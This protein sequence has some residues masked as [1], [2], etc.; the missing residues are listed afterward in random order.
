MLFILYAEA[1]QLRLKDLRSDVTKE[2]N[3]RLQADQAAMEQFYQFFGLNL[4]Y[5]L[6]LTELKDLFPDT[7][8]SMLKKCFEALRMYDL[9]EIIAKVK[10]HSL[11]PALSPE[12]IEKLWRA[13]DR[14]TKYHSNVAVLVVNH[15]VKGDI[16]ERNE[17]KKIETFF[18]D[19]NSRNEVALVSLISSQ[20]TR[21]V[22]REIKER[23]SEMRYYH[24]TEN[25]S[26]KELRNIVQTKVRL[27]KRLEEAMQME[28]VRRELK[29]TLELELDRLE[30]QEFM[31]RGDLENVAKKKK[32]EERDF[33]NLKELEKE[34]TKPISK[35]MDE[36]IHNQ[37]KLTSYTCM[38]VYS[39][40]IEKG[41]LINIS[42]PKKRVKVAIEITSKI[43]D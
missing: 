13:G 3:L 30:Q 29:Q 36:L 37:G 7:T 38:H 20:E 6:G 35:T 9:A 21:K 24:L 28:K 34:S 12:R 32:Q 15:S 33:E 11:R 31:L 25:S 39:N 8:V 23:N 22:L 17:A 40:K 26:R 41:G 27:E 2:L 10:S 14:P 16:V 1:D 42:D 19:L 4:T 18:K 43:I 5:R